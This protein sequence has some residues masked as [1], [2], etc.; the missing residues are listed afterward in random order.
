M[1][2]EN[3]FGIG[4]YE[5]ELIA[6][7]FREAD[8]RYKAGEG[9]IAEH[10]AEFSNRFGGLNFQVIETV[11]RRKK[12]HSH[13]LAVPSYPIEKSNPHIMVVDFD[14]LEN[15]I[16]T[17]VPFVACVFPTAAE[18]AE[19]AKE[20]EIPFNPQVNLQNLR[21]AGIYYQRPEF[22]YKGPPSSRGLN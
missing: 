7:L 18:R 3:E 11:L 20:A 4:P 6:D 16:V 12:L 17:K 19:F 1:G 22:T 15:G 13:L 10:F 9:S 2:I 8:L 21:R 14:D 5:E